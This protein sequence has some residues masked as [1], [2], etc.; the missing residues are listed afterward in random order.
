MDQAGGFI[1]QVMP[2]AQEEVIARLE[3]N[4]SK[5]TSVT[6]ILKEGHTPESLLEVVLSGFDYQVN[7]ELIP[8]FY[9]NCSK[10]RVAKVLI[11][12]GEK[13]LQ[14]LIDE[15]KPAELN[16]HF[17]NTSYVFTKEELSQLLSVVRGRGKDGT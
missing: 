1:V 15:D 11:S 9:C 14:S 3:E 16:C 2:Y 17:C 13:D 8:R 6:D 7:E 10:E 4:V 12:I 5:I